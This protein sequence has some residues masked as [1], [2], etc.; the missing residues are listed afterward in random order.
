MTPNSPGEDFIRYTVP[1]FELRRA[2]ADARAAGEA[3]SLVYTRLTVPYGNPNTA[4]GPQVVLEEDGQGG[5]KC[6]ISTTPPTA[7]SSLAVP[8]SA[9]EAAVAEPPPWWALKFAVFWAT[10][11]L[12][13]TTEEKLGYCQFE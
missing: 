8:C 7:S 13:D 3:F 1:A 11:V 4:T 12:E 2:L 10:P 9:T 6:L 5:S